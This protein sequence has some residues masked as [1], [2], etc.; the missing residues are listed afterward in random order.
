MHPSTVMKVQ[1]N[2]ISPCKVKA[3]V[4]GKSLNTKTDKQDDNVTNRQK[5]RHKGLILIKMDIKVV[6]KKEVVRKIRMIMGC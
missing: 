3:K 5:S 2:T 4:H 1:Y 6:R